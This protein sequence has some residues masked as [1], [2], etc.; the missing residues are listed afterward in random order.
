MKKKTLLRL[1]ALVMFVV[2]AVFVGVALTH[3][4]LGSTFYLFGLPIGAAIW[5]AFYAVY[6][7]VMILLFALSFLLKEHK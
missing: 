1:I 5:R 4:E 7:A 6:T 2:A 3:P